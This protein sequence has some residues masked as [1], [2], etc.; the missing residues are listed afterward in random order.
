MSYK[1]AKLS[2][3]KNS[4]TFSLYVFTTIPMRQT[5]RLQHLQVEFCIQWGIGLAGGVVQ[6]WRGCG[7]AHMPCWMQNSTSRW[8][9]FCVSRFNNRRIW[10]KQRFFLLIF[11]VSI[12]YFRLFLSFLTDSLNPSTMIHLK[13]TFLPYLLFRKR[14]FLCLNFLY[15]SFPILLREIS[16]QTLS[17]H[18]DGAKTM[19]HFLLH[20]L[21]CDQFY[22]HSTIVIYKS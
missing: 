18:N 3:S 11:L 22:Q 10:P 7:S 15:K 5:D 12:L 13:N 9:R 8:L 21:H 6:Y 20:L 1:A 19:K 16:T 17:W 2:K 14:S 4:Q